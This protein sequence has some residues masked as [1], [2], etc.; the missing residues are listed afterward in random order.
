MI[1]LTALLRMTDTSTRHFHRATIYVMLTWFNFAIS[2]LSETTMKAACP[3]MI[4]AGAQATAC[5]ALSVE[6]FCHRLPI[7]LPRLS[8]MI[9][10]FT[11]ARMKSHRHLCWS[12]LEQMT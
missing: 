9:I 2:D 3:H 7:N 1:L 8:K 5:H 10:S 4:I 11:L 6:L 12:G